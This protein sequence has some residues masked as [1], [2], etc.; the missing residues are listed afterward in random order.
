MGVGGGGAYKLGVALQ[1]NQDVGIDGC[2]SDRVG[3]GCQSGGGGGVHV[4]MGREVACFN[5]ELMQ[6]VCW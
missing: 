6:M 5:S 2:I 3:F 1:Q 4:R